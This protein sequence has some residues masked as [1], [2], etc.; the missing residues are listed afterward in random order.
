MAA[1]RGYGQK[2]GLTKMAATNA[3]A[4]WEVE[5]RLTKVPWHVDALIEEG[6]ITRRDVQTL[7]RVLSPVLENAE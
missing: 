3:H 1:E 2:A 6:V 5:K 4:L 7:T